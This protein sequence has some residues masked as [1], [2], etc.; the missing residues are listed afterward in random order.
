MFEYVQ[1]KNQKNININSDKEVIQCRTY[2]TLNTHYGDYKGTSGNGTVETRM[3]PS[4]W[5]NTVDVFE[6]EVEEKPINDG[7]ENRPIYQCAEPN[8]LVRAIKGVDNKIN[9]TNQ[10]RVL[11]S[12]TKNW[13]QT[14]TFGE[15]S[16][17][18]G[19]T[20]PTRPCDVCAQW[21]DSSWKINKTSLIN[22]VKDDTEEKIINR[23][24]QIQSDRGNRGNRRR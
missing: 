11:N 5:S 16:S 10:Q 6:T 22:A 2:I 15:I 4:S 18:D 21:M 17:D 1:R 24:E 23:V 13:L 9:R 14:A 19:E 20:T 12:F 3:I 8:A 7:G